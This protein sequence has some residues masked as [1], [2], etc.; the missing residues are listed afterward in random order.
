MPTFI[1][2]YSHF[3]TVDARNVCDS[4]S[5]LVRDFHIPDLSRCA[6]DQA[7]KPPRNLE[8]VP[9]SLQPNGGHGKKEETFNNFSIKNGIRRFATRDDGT[10]TF[11]SP[12]LHEQDNNFDISVR[13]KFFG[14]TLS[15][16]DRDENGLVKKIGLRSMDQAGKW[17]WQTLYSHPQPS[18]ILSETDRKLHELV[19]LLESND[20]DNE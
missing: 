4:S 3:C 9:A 6:A 20:E 15:V 8:E 7:W 17:N 2:T 19:K 5:Q 11:S 16:V 10:H 12:E 13:E 1:P 14:I 18:R